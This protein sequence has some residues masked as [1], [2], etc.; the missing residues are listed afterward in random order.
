MQGRR[1]EL[2]KDGIISKYLGGVVVVLVGRY[3]WVPAALG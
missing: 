2:G 3:P 1:T